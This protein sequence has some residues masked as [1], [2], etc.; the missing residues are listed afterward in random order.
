MLMLTTVIPD[1]IPLTASGVLDMDLS[2]LTPSDVMTHGLANLASS[3]TEPPYAARHG[4]NPV[5]TFPPSKLSP[6]NDQDFFEKSYPSLF[7]YGEGG[8]YRPRLTPLSFGEH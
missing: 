5:R 1:M 3:A 2:T 4:N 6:A 7:P 8:F